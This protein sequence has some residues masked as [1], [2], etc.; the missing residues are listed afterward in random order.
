VN[1]KNDD[2]RPLER[3]TANITRRNVA[4][5]VVGIGR[6]HATLATLLLLDETTTPLQRSLRAL[7]RTLADARKMDKRSRVTF[8]SVG[9]KTFA[10]R[11]GP[12]LV[13]L[14]AEEA[15]RRAA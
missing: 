15:T 4:R 6:S 3:P 10:N 13:L 1:P 14:E 11:F 12:E 9:A 8:T 2:G 7:R 5:P